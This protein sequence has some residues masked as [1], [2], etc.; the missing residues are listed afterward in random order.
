[1][2]LSKLAC[3]IAAAIGSIYFVITAIAAVLHR[4][5]IARM[6]IEDQ[7]VWMLTQVA[8][9]GL[10]MLAVIANALIRIAMAIPEQTYGADIS[11][12]VS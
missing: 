11:E 7:E 3:A 9:L 4:L 12:R 2:T 8:G 10:L 6:S 5:G 1:M